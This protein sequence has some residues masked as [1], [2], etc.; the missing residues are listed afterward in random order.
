[1]RR[2]SVAGRSAITNATTEHSAVQFWNPSTTTPVFIYEIWGVKTAAVADNLALVKT[3]VRG[4]AGSVVTPTIIN[5][6]EVDP[7]A[8]NSGVLLDLAAFTVQPT[9][10]TIYLARANLA[11][12]I[13]ASFVWYFNKPI[14]IRNGGVAVCVPTSLSIAIQ[15][16]DFTFVWSE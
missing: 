16:A 8:P 13:G 3:T 2:F 6:L 11:A 7:I 10:S 15:P 1:M 4:T 9:H 5:C 12:S 14:A